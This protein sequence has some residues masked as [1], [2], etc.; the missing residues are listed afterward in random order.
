[1]AGPARKRLLLLEPPFHRL[2]SDS[3]GLKRFPLG[4]GYLAGAARKL[5][6]WSVGLYAADFHPD[7]DPFDQVYLAGE[8]YE[9][10]LRRLNDPSARV[11]KE[12]AGKVR[13]FNPDVVGITIKTPALASA[14]I[15]ARLVKSIR[16]ET[17][18]VVGGP[19]ASAMGGKL[20]ERPCFDSVVMGQ[21][22][23][24]LVRL[25]TAVQAGAK[26]PPLT[27]SPR[28][29]D[30]ISET[31]A[32]DRME[33]PHLAARSC[34]IDGQAYPA[35]AF[36]HVF[37]ARGCPNNCSYCSS[38]V[39]WGRTVRTRSP[40]SVRLEIE[41]LLALGVKRIHFDDDT[42][43]PFPARLK[44]LCREIGSISPS[45]EFS[46]ET[47]VSLVSERNLEM[48]A[49]AGCRMI[50]LGLESGDD[51][52]LAANRKRTTAARA[53][54]ACQAVKRQGMELQV[55][56]MAGLPQDTEQSLLATLNLIRSVEMDKAIYSVFTP[57]PGTEAWRT[58]LELGLVNE[59][60]DFSLHN[61]QSPANF[62]CP[63]VRP[64]RFRE[65]ARE[66]ESAVREKNRAFRAK[67]RAR[68][69]C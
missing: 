38:S 63:A 39:V 22:E 62:F 45:F 20:L 41:S 31:E 46:C 18:V 1:M 11:W 4:L 51:A 34:L 28:F 21:G 8:G 15:T 33:F 47:H 60:Y 40:R 53:L 3:Y 10:Y 26:P 42:F 43:G 5:E 48:M 57:Y 32:L 19:H 49:R 23:E 13:D 52:V 6:G 27:P 68:G 61:H 50:Q 64:E 58:C 55:F 25:L 44:E 14:E 35:Q 12:L 24:A 9:R 66:M 16:P 36:G 65:L 7:P 2:Y 69:E 54:K 29:R 59:D 30:R 17:L 67:A 37:T 56:F